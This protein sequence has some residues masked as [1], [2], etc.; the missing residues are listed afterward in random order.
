MF[1]A[2]FRWPAAVTL[3]QERLSRPKRQGLCSTL[4]MSY[5][6]FGGFCLPASS[7]LTY[8]AVL[9]TQVTN[10]NRDA[11]GR[12]SDQGADFTGRLDE[13]SVALHSKTGR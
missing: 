11:S 3:H 8:T 4:Q 2:T 5:P 1:E 7:A 12:S 13:E 10:I 6:P 9:L